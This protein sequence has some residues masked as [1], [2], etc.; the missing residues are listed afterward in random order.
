MIGSKKSAIALSIVCLLGSTSPV[1]AQLSS[2]VDPLDEIGSPH[3][4]IVDI[5][6]VTNSPTLRSQSPIQQ[7]QA[8]SSAWHSSGAVEATAVP[9]QNGMAQYNTFSADTNQYRA[10]TTAPAA[11]ST[12]AQGAGKQPI[13]I[14]SQTVGRVVGVAGTALILGAFL[15]NGGVG[16]MMNTFGLDNRFHSRGSSLA[17]Y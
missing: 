12:L 16:G 6:I 2:G 8:S 14:D 17:P 10:S 13:Q 15:K 5:D 9:Q 4:K 11:G 7:P 3:S 1:F